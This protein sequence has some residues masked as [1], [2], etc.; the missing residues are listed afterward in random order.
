[1]AKLL[2]NEH[3]IALWPLAYQAYGDALVKNGDVRQGMA[4]WR[5]GF[6]KYPLAVGLQE[7][8]ASNEK[9]ALEIVKRD[10][11][12]EFFQRPDAGISDISIVWTNGAAK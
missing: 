10:R 1:V 5:E 11:G 9:E 7:R 12:I 4:V 2:E 3:N 8:S 6:A